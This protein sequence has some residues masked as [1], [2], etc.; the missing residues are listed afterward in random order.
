MGHH[1]QEVGVRRGLRSEGSK[2]GGQKGGGSKDGGP[3]QIKWGPEGW[4]PKVGPEGWRAQN[5]ALFFH[6]P[7]AKFVLFF[8]LWRSF[9]GIFLVFEVGGPGERRSGKGGPG[10]TEHDQTKTLKPTHARETPHHETMKPT[11]THT[12]KHT[13]TPH[14]THNTQHHK[15]KS[16]WPKSVLAKVGFD[17]LHAVLAPCRVTV[18]SDSREE[19]ADV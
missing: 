11:P 2:G 9:R 19:S 8:P 17:H 10:S 18:E 14:T 5:F 3:T 13:N 1:G 7:A 6:S 12:H 15:S 4:G 16:V